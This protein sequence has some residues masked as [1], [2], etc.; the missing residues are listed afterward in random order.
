MSLFE[1]FRRARPEVVDAALGPLQFHKGSWSGHVTI[2]GESVPIDVAGD[3]DGPFAA[4]RE[5]LIVLK[6]QYATLTPVIGRELVRLGTAHARAVS[7][8]AEPGFPTPATPAEALTVFTLCGVSVTDPGRP[9]LLFTYRDQSD[10]S[11]FELTVE[12]DRVH[13][14]YV[15]D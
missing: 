3:P 8:V 9:L 15:G 2:A 1:W 10:D 11:M 7:D 5:A 6:E 14:E 13:G 4:H 12:R